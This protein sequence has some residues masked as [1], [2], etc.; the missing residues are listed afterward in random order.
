MKGGSQGNVQLEISYESSCKITNDNHII[1]V[2]NLINMVMKPIY[3]Y[4]YMGYKSRMDM[5]ISIK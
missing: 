3:I 4:E 5:A 1:Y 2:W